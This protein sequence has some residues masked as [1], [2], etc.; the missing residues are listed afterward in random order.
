M[1][2]NNIPLETVFMSNSNT[3]WRDP[4]I[5][6]RIHFN[7]PNNW[8][9]RVNNNKKIIGIRNM[10]I[11]RAFKH[12]IVSIKFSLNLRFKTYNPGTGSYEILTQEIAKRK[13][14]VGK[15]FDV[16]VVLKDYLIKIN[17]AFKE[18]D[19]FNELRF[20]SE[21]LPGI[22]P[23]YYE[24]IKS[25]RFLITYFEFIK[26]DKHRHNLRLV[27]KSPFNE[28]PEEKRSYVTNDTINTYYVNFDISLDNEDANKLFSDKV[29]GYDEEPIYFNQLWD[30]NSCI[31]YSNISEECDNGYLGHTRKYS[32]A[33]SIKYFIVNNNMR[34]FWVD[35]FATCDHKAPVVLPQDDELVIEAQLF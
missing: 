27:I 9:N 12:P 6:N 23:E 4:N 18:I 11:S 3:S 1:N 8:V 5:K 2:P 20:D 35:L 7:L 14:R 15:F 26:P 30:H 25:T 28:L 17:Q 29:G 32:L 31:L 16:D 22:M 19:L 10:F 24:D 33:P 13:L 34:S 21:Q